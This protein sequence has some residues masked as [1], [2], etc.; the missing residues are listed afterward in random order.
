MTNLQLMS[1]LQW[2]DKLAKYGQLVLLFTEPRANLHFLVLQMAGIEIQN[3]PTLL[4][5]DNGVCCK[6]F[7]L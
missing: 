2:T 1:V 5:I 7:E 3:S 6:V 4:P